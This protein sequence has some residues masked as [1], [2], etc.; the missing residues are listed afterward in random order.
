MAEKKETKKSTT[1]KT[2][3][4]DTVKKV[5]KKAEKKAVE[6]AGVKNVVW[7]TTFK[8]EVSYTIYPKIV[9]IIEG[10][11]GA[12]LNLEYLS[13]GVEITFCSPLENSVKVTE[14]IVD[15]SLGKA[16]V[17]TV[18]EGYCEYDLI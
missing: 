7:S 15:Y 3:K 4:K 13:N 18:S 17:L 1:T 9:K 10:L 12:V 8:T 11:E 16:E 6:K 2:V 14:K 5:E